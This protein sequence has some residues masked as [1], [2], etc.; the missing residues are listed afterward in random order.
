MRH[1]IFPSSSPF[2]MRLGTRSLRASCAIASAV[3][4]GRGVDGRGGPRKGGRPAGRAPAVEAG[5]GA[6]GLLAALLTTGLAGE[7]AT[8]TGLVA[9]LLEAVGATGATAAGRTTGVG[10]TGPP[11]GLRI[12]CT[13]G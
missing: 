12:T 6:E 5:R 7:T 11:A 9:G 10:L 8:G 13:A 3:G 4:G 2:A 1:F